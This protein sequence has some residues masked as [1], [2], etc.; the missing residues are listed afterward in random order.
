MNTLQVRHSA[1]SV[2]FH[3]VEPVDFTDDSYPQTRGDRSGRSSSDS[4]D[5]GERDDH[6]GCMERH[7]LAIIQE[8]GE[9][10]GNVGGREAQI[11]AEAGKVG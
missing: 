9:G 6:S 4:G 7:F 1:T 2:H 10:C 11:R 5:E 8:A 3:F